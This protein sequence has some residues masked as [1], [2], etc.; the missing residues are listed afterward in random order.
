MRFNRASPLKPAYL[1]SNPVL[2]DPV[3]VSRFLAAEVTSGAMAG[4]F[5]SP[6][7]PDLHLS[8]FTLMAKPDG[9]GHRLLFD[10]SYPPGLSGNDGIAKPDRSVQYT[11]LLDVVDRLTQH[12]KGTLM[13][14][15]DMSRAYR[16]VPIAPPDRV[17]LGLMWQNSYYVDLTLSFGGASCCSIF[18]EVADFLAEL[19]QNY[20]PHSWWAHYLDDFFAISINSTCRLEFSRDFSGIL[21]MCAQLRIPLAAPKT[22]FPTTKMIFLGMEIDSVAQTISLPAVKKIKYSVELKSLLAIR[23]TTKGKLESVLGMLFHAATVIPLGRAF[24][25]PLT[26]KVASRPLKRSFLSLSAEDKLTVRWWI[27]LLANWNGVSFFN[28]P[29]FAAPTDFEIASDAA[30]SVGLGILYGSEW[31]S[32][33]WPNPAPINIAV[34]EITPIVL[35]CELGAIVGPD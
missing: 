33:L 17:L 2:N 10:L 5:S 35:A 14:K 27:E 19:W 21:E 30:G 16:R 22:V 9:S 26:S 29:K 12:G 34:L 31:V 28:F 11:S 6:P 18:N 3:L 4:P 13:A 8:R 24:L 25:R 32:E 20:S 1:S 7:I 23:A 15:F